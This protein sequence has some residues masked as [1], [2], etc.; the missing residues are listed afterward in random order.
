MAEKR[1]LT[2]AMKAGFVT[3]S[4]LADFFDCPPKAARSL[5]RKK[6]TDRTVGGSARAGVQGRLQRTRPTT[7][8]GK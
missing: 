1:M 4:M 8:R 2:I 6:R 3:D 5:L 7:M